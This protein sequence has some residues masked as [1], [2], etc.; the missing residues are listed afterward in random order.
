MMESTPLFVAP[1]AATAAFPH[2]ANKVSVDGESVSVF[3]AF[4]YA[5]TFNVFDLPAVVV[6]AGSTAAGL[7]VGVQI[8]GRPLEEF[9]VLKAAGIVEAALGA[10][11]PQRYAS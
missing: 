11:S 2:H 7:P 3:R 10:S 1:V 8:V 5:Q 4:S 6:R 9:R